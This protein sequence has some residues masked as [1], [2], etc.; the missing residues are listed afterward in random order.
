MKLH[1]DL[2]TLSLFAALALGATG[3]T[4]AAT[5]A[6][7]SVAPA[8]TTH[9]VHHTTYAPARVYHSGQWLHYR[10]DG[11]YYHRH[12]SWV[13]APSVPSHVVSYHRP[14]R[15]VHVT[16]Q[17]APR[18]TH[19]HYQSRPTYH[20]SSGPVHVQRSVSERRTYYRR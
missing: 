17:Y 6:T 13:A 15:P 5:P 18:P 7:L 14:G 1:R 8:P 20:R 12:G 19:V 16:T 11:Y 4:I 10:S 2:L 9:V 3:C